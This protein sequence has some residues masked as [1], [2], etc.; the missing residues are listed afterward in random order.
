MVLKFPTPWY[1]TPRTTGL[2]KETFTQ[3]F[4]KFFRCYDVVFWCSSI[5]SGDFSEYLWYISITGTCWQ[6]SSKTARFPSAG[7]FFAGVED[8]STW[9]RVFNRFFELFSA[10]LCHARRWLVD[11]QPRA[12]EAAEGS[13]RVL[14]TSYSHFLWR[15]PRG[16]VFGGQQVQ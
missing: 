4:S 15:R 14:S 10:I 16:M 13:N 9:L 11:G 7:I 8:R 1:W 6:I 2:W 3:S 12:S 5:L